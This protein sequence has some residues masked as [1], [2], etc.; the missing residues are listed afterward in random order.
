[1]KGV[2]IEVV[3][4]ELRKFSVEWQI[5]QQMD[6]FVRDQDDDHSK[7]VEIAGVLCRSL[8]RKFLEDLDLHSSKIDQKTVLREIEGWVNKEV[9]LRKGLMSK[10]DIF[11]IFDHG[12]G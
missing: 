10:N 6:L 12:T 8:E 5:Q 4:K 7:D 2:D 9:T 11:T 1:M 3:K